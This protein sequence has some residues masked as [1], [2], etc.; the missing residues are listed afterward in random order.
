MNELLQWV[1]DKEEYELAHRIKLISEYID[2]N[3]I[4]EKT[5]RRFKED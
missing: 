5:V 4:R 1:V 2:K 3:G